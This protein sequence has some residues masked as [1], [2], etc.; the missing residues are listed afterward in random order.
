MFSDPNGAAEQ[1]PEASN[2]ST[3]AL[4]L[5]N[6]PAY[7]SGQIAYMKASNLTIAADDYRKEQ[8][9]FL[10]TDPDVITGF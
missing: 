2:D 5:A 9:D 8:I 6:W 4:E 10:N 3:S 7:S 1:T